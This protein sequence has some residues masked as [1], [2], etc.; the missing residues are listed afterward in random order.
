[1]GVEQ[2][3]T[4]VKALWHERLKQNSDDLFVIEAGQRYSYGQIGQLVEQAAKRLTAWGVQS[5]DIVALQ[6]ELDL[7][8]IVLLLACIEV[9]AVVN[10]L[11]PHFDRDEVTALIKRFKPYAIISQKSVRGRDTISTF[12]HL[13]NYQLTCTGDLKMFISQDRLVPVFKANEG[14]ADAVVILN[15]SGTSSAP[16]GVVLTNTNLLAA[17]AAYLQAFGIT[18]SDLTLLLSGMYHA[19]GFH[20]GLIATI[21][22]GSKIVLLKHYAIAEVA[23]LLQEEPITFIDS[24]PT[25]MY[26]LLFKVADLGQ[27]RQLICGGDQIK[28]ELLQQ[29]QKRNLP[30]YNCYGLTEA[31]PFSYTPRAYYQQ[32]QGLTTAVTPMAGIKVRLVNDQQVINQANVTGLVEV[33][34][35]VIFKEYLGEPEKTLATFDGEWLKT[36]DLAHYNQ[37]GLLE[38]EGRSGDR[39]IRGGEKIAACLVEE[40]LQVCSN[41]Q[42]IAVIGIPDMRLGQ[43]I[44]AFIVPRDQ[45]KKITKAELLAELSKHEVDKKYWPEKI[46]QLTA[47]P[48]TVNGK[49]KKYQLTEYLRN[50]ASNVQQIF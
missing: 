16:K 26:D 23:K 46:W 34:G 21:L 25:V 47:L 13:P 1:M 42:E 43:R 18:K 4:T 39:I 31:V 38:I 20:H 41:I 8:N 9:G 22:A 11:N 49:I 50:Q 30:L 28:R 32:Q 37:A 24:L 40:K 10:P 29:A 35:P 27:L 19:I 17:E 14:P 15:T 33:K 3:L 2:K 44:G 7:E 6:F 36:G 45:Q 5:G 12:Q 48:R